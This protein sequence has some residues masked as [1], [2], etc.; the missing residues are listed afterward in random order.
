MLGTL[1]AGHLEILGD[2]SLDGILGDGLF[3][4]DFGQILLVGRGDLLDG[5]GSLDGLADPG[6]AV[7]AHHAFDLQ[8]NFHHI[9]MSP[10]GHANALGYSCIL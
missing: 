1:V 7:G 10:F 4:D 3:A 6:F 9:F 5:K 8:R 2:D